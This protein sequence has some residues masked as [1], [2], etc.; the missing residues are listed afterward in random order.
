MCFMTEQQATSDTTENTLAFELWELVAPRINRELP[1]VSPKDGEEEEKQLE[2][3]DKAYITEMQAQ[4]V[5]PAD[6]KTVIMAILRIN[7]GKHF[8]NAKR[9]KAF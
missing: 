4:E 8:F 1:E 3:L 7:D 5:T 6:L 2:M 9:L